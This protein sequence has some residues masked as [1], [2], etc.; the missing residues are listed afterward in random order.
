MAIDGAAPGETVN[1]GVGA[2]STGAGET[3][4]MVGCVG[5]AGGAPAGLGATIA[6]CAAD[7]GVPPG[8]DIMDGMAFGD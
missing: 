6:G 4:A 7:I 1:V 5:A 2:C 8:A 3:I